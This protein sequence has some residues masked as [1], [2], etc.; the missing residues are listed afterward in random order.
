MGVMSIR[1]FNANISKAFAEVE[2]GE[3]LVLTR[4]GKPYLRITRDGLYDAA[5]KREAAIA[6]LRALMDEGIDFGGPA[7]YGERTGR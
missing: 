1:E 2:R 4:S 7:S 3:D 6:E 5:L